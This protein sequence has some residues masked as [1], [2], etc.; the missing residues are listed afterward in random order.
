MKAIDLHMTQRFLNLLAPDEDVTFQT[1]ADNKAAS[2]GL[3]KAFHGRLDQ[4]AAELIDLNQRG[5]GVFVM[6]NRGDGII[7]AG[8]KTCRT[9]A[10]VIS[11]RALFAD[12]DG[13]P[14]EP[15]LA[16]APPPHIIVESSPGKWHT[17]WLTHDTPMD[18]FTD[19]QMAIA[20]LFGTD[21]AVKDLPRVMRLPGFLHQKGDPFQTRL[22]LPE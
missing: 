15:I 4:H 22:V 10:N 16:K 2:R 18:E 21:P 11:I 9:N 20:K 5:A 13:I 14:L 17:Y 12:A 1:F 8:N 6:V 19:R 7:H 3:A